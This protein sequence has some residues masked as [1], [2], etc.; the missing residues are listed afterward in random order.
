[1][2]AKKVSLKNFAKNELKQ[3]IKRMDEESISDLLTRINNQK[4]WDRIVWYLE[5]LSV[6]EQQRYVKTI[7]EIVRKRNIDWNVRMKLRDAV[8]KNQSKVILLQ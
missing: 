8:T 1:M 4:T 3:L 7:S 5:W 2:H 6:K